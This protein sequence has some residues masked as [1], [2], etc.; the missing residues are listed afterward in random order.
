[1]VNRN[2]NL[3]IKREVLQLIMESAKDSLPNEF[4]AILRAK[5]KLIYEIAIVPGTV[6]GERSALFKLFNL[7][8][9][10]SYVGTAHSHP[11]GVLIPSDEDLRLFSNFGII[12]IIV[13][14]P[15]NIESWRA[16]SKDG[17]EMNIEVI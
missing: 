10:Y 11:S 15:F 1:M 5:N 3:R 7:P 4:A 14:Y 12:H 6:A 17:K 16:F 8:I 9:D 2:H 13:G